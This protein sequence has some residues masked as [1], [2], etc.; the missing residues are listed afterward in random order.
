MN[1]YRTK[2]FKSGNS[3]AVRLPKELEIEPGVEVEIE[4][5]GRDFTIRRKRMTNKELVEA[6]RKL[7]KPSYVQEREPIEFPERPGL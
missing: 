4:R 3:T 6:L 1:A 5:N 2:T 7:P